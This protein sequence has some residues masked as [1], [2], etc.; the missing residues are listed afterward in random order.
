[1]IFLVLGIILNENIVTFAKDDET[2]VRY[3]K[4]SIENN[5][6][7]SNYNI[8]STENYIKND[9]LITKTVYQQP[10]GTIITDTLD[11]SAIAPASRN[12]SDTATRTRTIS[13]WGSVSITASFKWYT[14]GMFSYVK[15]TGMSASHSLDSRAKVSTWEK[16][17]TKDYVSI[18]TAKAQVKYYFY[19]SKNPA[20]YQD[21]TF[22][23]TCS[24]EGTISDNN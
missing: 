12:G 2:N 4:Y 6:N 14:K 7:L 9:R 3:V 20:Q 18:G 5:E 1:M 22:K 19:N 17:Y 8:I 23:I 10:D 15:C 24:D 16:N 11:I 21:G 13:G